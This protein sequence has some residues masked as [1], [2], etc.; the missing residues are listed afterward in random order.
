MATGA[1]PFQMHCTGVVRLQEYFRRLI[2]YF[3]IF[4][5]T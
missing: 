2:K 4:K 5:N 1:K 3:N